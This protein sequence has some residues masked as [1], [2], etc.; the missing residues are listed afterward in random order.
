MALTAYTHT[1]QYRLTCVVHVAG[2]VPREPQLAAELLDEYA[3][4]PEPASVEG[5]SDRERVRERVRER[6]TGRL[7]D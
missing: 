7:T 6:E 2:P 5:E 1:H 4:Y 3:A